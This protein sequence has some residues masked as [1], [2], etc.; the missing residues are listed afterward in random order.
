MGTENLTVSQQAEI[1]TEYAQQY[2]ASMKELDPRFR[3]EVTIGRDGRTRLPYEPGLVLAI[4]DGDKTTRVFARDVEAIR[5]DPLK[6]RLQM[7]PSAEAKLREALDTGRPQTLLSGEVVSADAASPLLDFLKLDTTRMR[8]DIIPQVPEPDQFIPLRIVFGRDQHAREIQ[9]LPFRRKYLGKRE[10][11]L[12]ST[13]RLP[14]EISLV[15]R[16]GK[17]KA[18]N[19]VSSRSSLVRMSLTYTTCSSVYH[20]S[21]NPHT[22]RYSVLNMEL[23]FFTGNG[24]IPRK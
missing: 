16:P 23:H 6:F 18:R 8:V 21:R 22:S 10:V 3:Y 12:S 19:S 9:Y 4:C 14:V 13:G 15:L 17:R 20:H 11:T 1:T 24:Q 7:Q 2:L 5:L